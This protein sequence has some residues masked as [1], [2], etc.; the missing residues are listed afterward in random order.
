MMKIGQ[1]Y[2][3]PGGQEHDNANERGS[4]KDQK[5]S[6]EL[7]EPT[8]SEIQDDQDASEGDQIIAGCGRRLF[9]RER[10]YELGE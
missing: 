6:P 1:G 10:F 3:A 5:G 2:S 4:A 9:S 8:D 7:L